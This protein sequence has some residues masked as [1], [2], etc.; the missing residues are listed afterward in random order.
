MAASLKV[1]VGRE[2][3]LEKAASFSM[4][5]SPK[6]S[7]NAYGP[8]RA[9]RRFV[10]LFFQPLVLLESRAVTSRPTTDPAGCTGRPFQW[11][12]KAGFIRQVSCYN[13][14]PEQ[15][16]PFFFVP[17]AFFNSGYAHVPLLGFPERFIPPSA[18]KA[19]A[20]PRSSGVGLEP[21]WESLGSG[22]SKPLW[23]LRGRGAFLKKGPSPPKH[24]KNLPSSKSLP[25]AAG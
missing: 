22:R 10:P 2:S 15:C 21:A 6:D 25:Q 17:C 16:R 4:P 18:G 5:A 23:Q 13:Q 8:W 12:G 3:I 20:S 7:P 24:H 9:V 1:G 11:E 19:L 14:S